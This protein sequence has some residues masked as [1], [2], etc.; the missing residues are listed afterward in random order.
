MKKLFLT[1]TICMFSMGIFA[2]NG[3]IDTNVIE[4]NSSIALSIKEITSLRCV[5]KVT[6]I[7][8]ITDDKGSTVYVDV[9]YIPCDD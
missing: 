1:L 7:I 6:T 5:I 4:N 8:T 2:F 3:N 9:S